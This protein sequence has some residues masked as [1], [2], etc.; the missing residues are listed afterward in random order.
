MV[1]LLLIV[2]VT[3][4]IDMMYTLFGP[5]AVMEMGPVVPGA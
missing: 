3:G 1:G 4:V 5:D 2:D